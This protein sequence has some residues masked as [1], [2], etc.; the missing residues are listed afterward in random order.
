MRKI[1]IRKGQHYPGLL[2]FSIPLPVWMKKDSTKTRKAKF[3][4][5]DSCLYDLQD[6][7]QWDVNKLFGFS[8]GQHHRGS[9]FRFGWRPILEGNLIEIVAYEYHDGFRY[10]TMPI[11]KVA[12]NQWHEFTLT[13]KNDMCRTI[14]KVNDVMFTN[15]VFLAKDHGLGYT[16]GVYFGG[17]EKAPHDITIHKTKFK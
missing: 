13:Y 11:C 9:S 15:Q 4:F 10:K 3:M 6:E 12:L 17:N 1:K 16:L 2:P 5:T 8:I 7:D 14:Y